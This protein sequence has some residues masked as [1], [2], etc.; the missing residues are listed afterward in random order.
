[1]GFSALGRAG[2]GRIELNEVGAVDSALDAI[3]LAPVTSAVVSVVVS[4]VP[5][6]AT[7]GMLA[8]GLAVV[9]GVRR[10]RASALREG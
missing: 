10:P 3:A 1:M 8:L 6:P 5:E 2:S 7:W 9:A 4:A